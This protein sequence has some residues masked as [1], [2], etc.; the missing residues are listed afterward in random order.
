M[1]KLFNHLFLYCCLSASLMA[2]VVSSHLVDNVVIILDASGSMATKMGSSNRMLNAKAAINKIMATLPQTHHV[3]VLVFSD[4]KSA[5]GDWIVS[6]GPVSPVEI[7]SALQKVKASG[8]TPLGAYMEKARK[9]LLETRE[10]QSGYGTYRMLIVTDGEASDTKI[11]KASTPKTLNNGIYMDVI[12]VA[13]KKDHYL[14]GRAH[15]YRRANDPKSLEQAIA[16]VFAEVG[17]QADHPDTQEAFE[18]IAPLPND[19]I[20]SALEGLSNLNQNQIPSVRT[21]SAQPRPL[22]NSSPPSRPVNNTPAQP[23]SSLSSTIPMP[24]IIFGVVILFSILNFV[25]KSKRRG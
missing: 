18:L 4:M 2:D 8:G 25:S 22:K 24:Y 13:M 15:S 6:L 7:A 17:G 9:K 12:G 16:K 23:V 21:S 14:A 3:G 20:S 11:L 19:V 1:K 10:K 5:A